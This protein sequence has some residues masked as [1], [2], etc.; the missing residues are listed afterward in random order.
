MQTSWE[1][2]EN[3]MVALNLG[4]ETTSECLT[5]SETIGKQTILFNIQYI[6]L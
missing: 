5:V 4:Q 1:K 6:N 3:D 2:W